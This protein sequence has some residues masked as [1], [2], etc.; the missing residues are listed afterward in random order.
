MKLIGYNPTKQHIHFI[1]DL[2]ERE[3]TSYHQYTPIIAEAGN[4]FKLFRILG[5]NHA[6][7][8]SCIRSLLNC[9]SRNDEHD[10]LELDRLLLNYLTAA[11]TIQ[12]HFQVSFRRRFRK[13]LSRLKEY[14]DFINKLCRTSWAFA[15]FLDFRG[16]VQHCGLGIGNYHRHLS[17]TSVNL[18]ITSNPQALVADSNGWK[19]CKLAQKKRKLD[20]VDLQHEFHHH[21]LNSYGGFVAKTFF[22]ELFP[23]AKFYSELAKEVQKIDSGFRACFMPAIPEVKHGKGKQKMSLSFKLVPNDLFGE[24]GISISAKS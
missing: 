24:L 2:N 12:E 6:A 1:R 14:D 7:W 5:Q 13:D 18:S 21:M 8:T 11:Y 15:F 10:W 22:P 17:S 3:I 16:Y 4:R 9:E 19:R 20:L 23:A